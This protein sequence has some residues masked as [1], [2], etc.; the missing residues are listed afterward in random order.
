[1]SGEAIGSGGGETQ[2]AL[3]DLEADAATA[4]WEGI[5]QGNRRGSRDLTKLWR[6]RVR[7]IDADNGLRKN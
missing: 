5:A 2:I 7:G 1:M 3:R 6:P 4:P